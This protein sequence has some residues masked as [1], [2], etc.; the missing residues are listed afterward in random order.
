MIHKAFILGAGL[1]TRLRPLTSLRPKPLVPLFNRPIVEYAMDRALALGIQDIAINTHHLAEVWEEFYPTGTGAVY[2]GVNGVPSRPS[3]YREA[4]LSFFNEPELL[5]T[6][7]G[8]ANLGNWIGDEDDVL[9]Y[10]GDIFCS[11]PLEPLIA[12]HTQ[13]D[14][15]A[16]LVLRS[17][18]PA[19]H[20]AIDG[21]R[22]VD[23][24]NKLDRAVGTHQFTGIYAIKGRLL[25]R[26]KPNE[27]ESVIRAFL[28]LAAEGG[29]GAV[30]VDEGEWVDLGD[31]QS[32]MAAHASP[33][34][35]PAGV[36]MVHPDAQVA[37]DAT[38][39]ESWVGAGA[40][41]HSG[42]SLTGTVMWSNT[43]VAAGASASE[44][45]IIN[46]LPK[47]ATVEGEAV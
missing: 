40:V 31:P 32:Y 36:P 19:T 33:Q 13:G 30:V 34:M 43:T 10:N 46:G 39:T 27:K 42:A 5:E 44:A 6:G 29:L 26:L 3:G 2:A 7:G 23:I 25:K 18:G 20:I 38:V 45:I 8:I 21:E 4:A 24:H 14:Y 41:V 12:Q 15:E 47:G 28:D 37:D 1:G 11:I 35:R 16:T 22:I 9:I 17:S